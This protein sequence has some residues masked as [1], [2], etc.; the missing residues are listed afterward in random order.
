MLPYS[1]I[2]AGP[3]QPV[4][5]WNR[6]ARAAIGSVAILSAAAS[7]ALADTGSQGSFANIE[8]IADVMAR[9][10]VRLVGTANSV[11]VTQ[12]GRNLVVD[13]YIEGQMNRAV[14]QAN[15]IKQTGDNASAT[16]SVS[17]DMNTFSVEQS[18]TSFAGAGAGRN[19][20]S[21]AI[22]GSANNAA[23]GQTNDFGET[24]FNSAAL[25]QTG[26]GNNAA[27]YQTV[28]P[29]DLAAGGNMAT[30]TQTGNDNDALI[31][32]TGADNSASI[33]Q[34][35]SNNKG[36]ILQDGEGLSAVLMQT[37]DALEYTINQ[38]G[39]VIATGCGTVVVSQGAH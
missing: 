32:Q 4:N 33:E 3:F 2:G 17:G 36:A 21:I 25:T 16:V 29:A 34:D 9:T 7:P 27:I 11:E 39:C 26:H 12:T 6:A 35:G 38:T 30:I 20:A 1:V 24:Y 10:N 31:E 15:T 13:T 28:S 22:D 19:D 8:Q 5:R 18:S 14:S 23:I 37:G